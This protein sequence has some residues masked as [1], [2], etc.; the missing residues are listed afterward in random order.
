M[1]K[2]PQTLHW[3]ERSVFSCMRVHEGEKQTKQLSPLVVA[4]FN[5][6]EVYLGK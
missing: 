3:E 6:M 4:K 1:G 5:F 2:F